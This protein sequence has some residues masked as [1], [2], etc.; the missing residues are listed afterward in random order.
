M[1]I[2]KSHSCKQNKKN[3]NLNFNTQPLQTENFILVNFATSGRE[4]PQSLSLHH[5]VPNTY[6]KQGLNIPP[7]RK[8]G[9]KA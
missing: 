1:K 8:I 6:K 4:I 7:F 9:F 2:L 5:G 3:L